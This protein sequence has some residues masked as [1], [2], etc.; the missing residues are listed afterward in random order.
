MRPRRPDPREAV[1]ASTAAPA[2]AQLIDRVKQARLLGSCAEVRGWDEQTYMPPRGSAHRA[3]QMG[4]LARL[5]HELLTA[6]A[7]GE[8]LG[9]AEALKAGEPVV[10][11]NLREIRRAYDRA[12]KL[13][14]ELVAE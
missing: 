9:E 7:I 12:V 11:A 1:M 13:P 4:L 10:A 3:E 6:P 8:L 14:G 2:Y 5:T